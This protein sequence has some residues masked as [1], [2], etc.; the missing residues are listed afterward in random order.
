MTKKKSD[1]STEVDVKHREQFTNLT[2]MPD[3]PKIENQILEFWENIGAFERLVKKNENSERWP[4]FDGPITANNPMG[5]HHAWGRTLKDAYQRYHAMLGYKL[6]Y[7]NG[8]D[9]QGLWVEVEVEKALGL[10]SK[11]DI[12]E[13]GVDKFSIAC[14]ERV[15]RF[16]NVIIEQS[17]RLGQWMDWG[18]DY[19]TYDD[20]NIEHIW[21]F[22]KK[23][24]EN[25][26]LYQGERVMQ[27]CPRCET[28]LSA[29][30]MADSY[31][32]LTHTAVFLKLP[33]KGE[34]NTYFIVWTTT[35]WT[36]TANTALAVHADLTYL[37]VEENSTRYYL[38][39]GTEH[40]LKGDWEEIKQISG[41]DL[42]GKEFTG[43]FEDLPVQKNLE[44]RPVIK[45]DEVSNDEGSGIVHIAPG[46]GV[47]D[48][49]LGEIHDLQV[50]SPIDETGRF[51]EDYKYLAGI[52]T[53]EAVDVII[54]NLQEKGLLYKYENYT[55]RYPVCWRCK[56]ELVFKLEHEWFIDCD[57]IRPLL[58][59]TAEK[60]LW[61]PPYLAKDMQNWLNNMDDWCISRKRYWG[62]PLPF[63]KCK[64]CD[65]LTVVGTT[66][67]LAELAI[68]KDALES[69]PELHKPWID[70]I[71]IECPNCGEEV[72]RIPAV[73]DCW[74]DAGIVPFSTLHYL[75]D[76][77]HEYWKKWFPAELI[78]EM[79]EQIRLWF[80]S[81]LFMSV[82]IIG[83]TPYKRVIAFEEVRDEKG[84][85][86]SKTAANAITFDVAAEK[87]GADI[88]RWMYSSANLKNQLNFGFNL[89][90][91]VKRKMLGLWN[92]AYFLLS[93]A[94]ADEYTMNK[95]KPYQER[96]KQKIIDKWLLAEV[97][98]SLEIIR[99][100][101]D[102]LNIQKVTEEVED[103]I[104]LISNW[105]VRMNRRRFWKNTNDDDKKEAYG[106]L[107]EAL[108]VLIKA[109]API[110]PFITETLYQN[111]ATEDEY[112]TKPSV[113]LCSFPEVNEKLKNP[114]L[115]KQ[116]DYVAKVI[117][118]AL[119]LRNN[120]QLRI[121]LPLS[122]LDIYSIHPEVREAIELFSKQI[123]SELNVKKIEFNED[124]TES[125]V[126]EIQPNYSVV[127]PKFKEQLK[128]IEEKLT[129]MS[130]EKLNNLFQNPTAVKL[131]IKGDSVV[132]SEEDY[133]IHIKDKEGHATMFESD[134]MVSLDLELNPELKAEGYARDIVRYIQ[135]MRREI[136]LEITEEI[137]LAIIIKE[138]P[139]ELVDIV[140]EF[141]DYIA[142]ETL[143]A[144]VK[145]N[146]TL[147]EVQKETEMK[148]DDVAIDLQICPV[149]S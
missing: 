30:E 46:C 59:E 114:K 111:L 14:K 4:F 61:E 117:S 69:L 94:Q 85:R 133:D 19:F 68:D 146:E 106:T 58:K 8:F 21:F 13:Y 39:E 23:C 130:Q 45:W 110:V 90:K 139:S 138:M 143:A 113:H 108:I 131:D 136:D 135:N 7:Q 56:T 43:P 92:V 28:S 141:I 115:I 31:K 123:K 91:E 62:L 29:H 20:T 12:M 109:I 140:K 47:E 124:L 57:E 3:F 105:Y 116:F 134:I 120:S 63:Y 98:K 78:V 80:Y 86:M 99:H 1:I 76:E 75:E 148:V 41:K 65:Q 54:N 88:M 93:S 132:L 42:I 102:D 40:H 87:M 81:Q 104:E 74:L 145:F 83:D 147:E 100:S 32:Q 36:L 64:N 112:V 38:A 121:R 53:K 16:A 72:E 5:V 44:K 144:N 26:W 52:T 107:Y 125:I 137:N 2:K 84:E 18:N 49:E 96:E 33:V 119:K 126:F 11:K 82:T 127:G 17:K 60:V 149:N 48:Y 27:W 97:Q 10:N 34:E 142:S 73:G 35:P 24:H 89:G 25:G 129:E 95:I 103:F 66:K 6:R 37:L 22:L 50:I 70:D 15:K 67:E 51:L 77:A 122:S 128:Y 79:K 55:H 9:G 101:Y 71:T 118:M